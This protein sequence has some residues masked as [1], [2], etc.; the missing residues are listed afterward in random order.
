MRDL[1]LCMATIPF[2][3]LC[4][5]FF[6]FLSLSLSLPLSS[7]LSSIYPHSLSI[8]F[9]LAHSFLT[10]WSIPSTFSPLHLVT[11]SRQLFFSSCKTLIHNNLIPLVLSHGSRWTKVRVLTAP[12][13]G[14]RR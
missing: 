11:F 12:Q 14:Q 13:P 1:P 5:S 4:L 8:V 2:R 9:S 3:V 10:P 7:F 6:L